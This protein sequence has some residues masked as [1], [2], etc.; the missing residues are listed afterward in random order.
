MQMKPPVPS[1]SAWNGNTAAFVIGRNN[2]NNARKQN[3]D[4]PILFD[5]NSPR[6]LVEDK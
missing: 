6:H 5:S 3:E 1:I 4:L 2:N